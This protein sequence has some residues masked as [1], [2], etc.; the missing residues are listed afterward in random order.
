MIIY[1][2]K[3]LV[4]ILSITI[5][6]GIPQL[7]TAYGQSFSLD[8]LGM[9][10]DHK[11]EVSPVRDQYKSST[12]WSFAAVA[13]LE[14]ELLKAHK[15]P[16]DLSEMWFVRMAYIEKAR[17]YI[18][19]HGHINFPA[20][21]TT[22]DVI[23]IWK[24]YGAV[25]EAAYPGKRNHE[26]KIEHSVMDAQLKHYVDSLA[27]K[28]VLCQNE[29]WLN[30]FI[31]I[32]NNHLGAFDT[33][34]RYKKHMYTP[35]SFANTLALNPDDYVLISSF[36][37]HPYYQSFIPELPDNWACQK[38]IN[39]PLNTFT[40]VTDS[41]LANGFSVSWSA[42][43]TENGFVWEKALAFIAPENCNFSQKIDEYTPAH[44]CSN[45]LTIKTPL[46]NDS[47]NQQIR[48]EYFN[49]YLT[50]DDHA[51]QM[52]GSAHD[53]FGNK[54]YVVKN[55]WGT[56]QNPMKGYLYV[57]QNYFKLKSTSILV[58]KNAIPTAIIKQIHW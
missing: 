17:K 33:T 15:L 55:S 26:G 1:C 49:R 7:N 10:I 21:G 29:V 43:V 4:Y 46:L 12:C 56:T 37:H 28:K 30:G 23:F 36:N 19:M 52:V 31:K 54:Y 47:I 6:A 44:H 41:A 45:F 25:P 16:V 40:Q 27:N 34:F 38:A 18:R 13:M 14:S 11:V 8:A 3:R 42:D 22:T 35:H 53:K 24:K 50:T 58:N 9:Q 20:G 57:T 5:L 2:V 48:Q 32:L 51:M 39:L